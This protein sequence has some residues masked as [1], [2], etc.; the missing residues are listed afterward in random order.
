MLY[1]GYAESLGKDLDQGQKKTPWD[2]GSIDMVKEQKCSF[3]IKDNIY[4]KRREQK[5]LFIE[6]TYF[7]AVLL[8]NPKNI[9]RHGCHTHCKDN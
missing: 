6:S 3:Q 8:T 9:F 1:L 4:Q 2:V 5:F 7:T